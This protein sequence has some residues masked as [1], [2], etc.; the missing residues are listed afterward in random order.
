MGGG[1][2]VGRTTQA[3]LGRN[4]ILGFVF[5]YSYI[6]WICSKDMISLT[7]SWW[8]L[9]LALLVV[10]RHWHDGGSDRAPPTPQSDCLTRVQIASDSNLRDSPHKSYSAP[11]HKSYWHWF[12]FVLN[13]S[14]PHLL[15]EQSVLAAR[16]RAP[17]LGKGLGKSFYKQRY[18]SYLVFKLARGKD[19]KP[20]L[21]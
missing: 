15:L 7:L 19:S 3:N 1:A 13:P 4:F 12:G 20:C 6:E 14:P 9:W 10:T 21:Y 2:L 18:N 17:F 8:W 16:V 11:P 5:I